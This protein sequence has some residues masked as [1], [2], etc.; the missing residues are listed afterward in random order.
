MAAAD[1]Q[2]SWLLDVSSVE[3][4]SSLSDISRLLHE[5]LAQERGIEA[6]LD[7]LLNRRGELEQTLVTLHADST[8]VLVQAQV[9]PARRRTRPT[10][11]A[12]LLSADS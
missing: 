12:P 9:H 4:L 7:H 1:L 6:E 3:K 8:E 2:S 5:T 10:S 11:T